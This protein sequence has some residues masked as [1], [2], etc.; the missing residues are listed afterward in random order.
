MVRPKALSTAVVQDEPI[1]VK[2]HPFK[3]SDNWLSGL[4]LAAIVTCLLAI[5]TLRVYM[6]STNESAWVHLLMLTGL[7]TIFCISIFGQF[8]ISLFKDAIDYSKQ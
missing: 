5:I 2:S 3:A 7:C 4:A 8:L 6:T 1:E